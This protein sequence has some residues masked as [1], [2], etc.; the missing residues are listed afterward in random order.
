MLD[1]IEHS[2]AGGQNMAKSTVGN[3][4]FYPTMQNSMLSNPR[5][6]E[7]LFFSGSL[8]GAKICRFKAI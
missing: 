3:S 5:E 2:L 8:T 1:Q 6:K 7:V 4:C